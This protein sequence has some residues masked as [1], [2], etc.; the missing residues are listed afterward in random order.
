MPYQMNDITDQT[1]VKV[2]MANVELVFVMVVMLVVVT[3]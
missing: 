2:M 1:L 3:E